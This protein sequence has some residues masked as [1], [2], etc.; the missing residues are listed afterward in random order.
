MLP[1]AA[2]VTW[3]YALHMSEQDNRELD[4][5][6]R[7]DEEQPLP[8]DAPEADVAEQRTPVRDDDEAGTARPHA[9]PFDADEADVAEQQQV[10]HDD[11]D[12]YR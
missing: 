4:D 7:S 10:V 5:E 12:D 9:V 6:I 2:G 8:D 3:L 11:E 1:E